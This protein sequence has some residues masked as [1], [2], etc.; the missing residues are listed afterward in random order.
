M[1]TNL[2][3]DL[4]IFAAFLVAFEPGLTGIAIHEWLSLAFAGTIVLHILLHWSWITSLT[5][6]YFKKLFHASRL[7]YLVDWLLF[8]A[9]TVVMLSG[10]IIS[11]SVLATLGIRPPRAPVWRSLHSA[12]ADLML[13]LVG[14]HFAL[15]WSW[16]VNALS[17]VIV[18]PFRRLS[19]R[20]PLKPAQAA[21]NGDRPPE[22]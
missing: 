7:D 14:L 18:Q 4:G 12:S 21:A 13:L 5:S 20:T 3:V 1:K 2:L 22:G 6:T 11:E 8:A 16:T 15:H 17:R 9:F 19:S 10:L